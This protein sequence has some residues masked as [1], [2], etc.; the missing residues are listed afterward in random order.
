MK[1]K[2]QYK[3]RE[4]AGEHVVIMQGQAGGEMT[5]I[6]SEQHLAL[7]LAVALGQGISTPGLRHGFWSSATTSTPERPPTTRDAGSISSPS[8]ACW[9]SNVIDMAGLRKIAAS[10]MLVV[11]MAA[12]GG[13]A[14][15][16]LL[17]D[18]HCHH[19]HAH[20]SA[21]CICHGQEFAEPC[22]E[23][24][25]ARQA[26][27]YIE[28]S[29]KSDSHNTGMQLMQPA[30]GTP[31]DNR[32][33]SI[34]PPVAAKTRLLS[35]IAAAALG[36]ARMPGIAPGASRIDLSRRRMPACGLPRI[37]RPAARRAEPVRAVPRRRKGRKRFDYYLLNQS[38]D[39]MKTIISTIL[40]LLLFPLAGMAQNITGRVIDAQTGGAL[41]GASIS[42]GGHHER[43]D[44]S[45]GRQLHA[46]TQQR[47]LD[48]YH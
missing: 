27:I 23:H 38:A 11:Y 30:Y 39:N 45:G 4:M 41:P 20:H 21:D 47:L 48:A 2:E 40:A 33:Y 17:C 22:C 25:H 31:D 13:T 18:H 42:W 44:Q 24:V 9:S 3:V 5:R 46:R 15:A 35:G 37:L 28:L 29:T 14:A 34:M 43:H 19:N 36:V 10:L 8:A 32:Q 26:D 1:I 6:V 12:S 16:S 7:S